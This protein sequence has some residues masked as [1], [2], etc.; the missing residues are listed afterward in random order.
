MPGKADDML[1]KQSGSDLSG[2]VS[3]LCDLKRSHTRKT[4][5][6]RCMTGMEDEYLRKV[7]LNHA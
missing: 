5:M 4:E 6:G 7:Y 2:I 3:G 1:S